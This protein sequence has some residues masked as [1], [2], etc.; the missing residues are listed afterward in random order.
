MSRNLAAIHRSVCLVLTVVVML[1]LASANAVANTD[2]K[3][4]EPRSSTSLH[5]KEG[6]RSNNRDRSKA[7][8]SSDEYAALKTGGA[9]KPTVNL[10]VTKPVFVRSRCQGQRF[11]ARPRKPPYQR[12]IRINI[13]R[14][15]MLLRNTNCSSE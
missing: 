13:V 15:T 6:G 7:E 8:E 5:Y 4:Q 14:P 1:I 11:V 3:S 10:P 2:V 12:E 9:R